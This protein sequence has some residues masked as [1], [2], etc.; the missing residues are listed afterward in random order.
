[1][2]SAQSDS[3]L[4][5][6]AT[7]ELRLEAS[8]LV[9]E[10]FS[11]YKAFQALHSVSH[12]ELLFRSV[13]DRSRSRI[14]ALRTAKEW[15]A[16]I[17]YTLDPEPE[18]EGFYTEKV[19]RGYKP[20]FGAS[21]LGFFLAYY[22]RFTFEL[23]EARLRKDFFVFDDTFYQ[24]LG[25]VLVAPSTYSFNSASFAAA[26]QK[27]HRVCLDLS[28]AVLVTHREATSSAGLHSATHSAAVVTRSFKKLAL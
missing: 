15:V 14:M 2:A 5:G 26:Q 17:G 9:I 25:G 3:L 18:I 10:D 27:Q 8:A 7:K 23:F 12:Q 28:K 19:F 11:S 13:L 16:V 6:Q 1:M 20:A 22:A 21:L 4:A 24:K